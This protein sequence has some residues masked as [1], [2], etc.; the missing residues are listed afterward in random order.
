MGLRRLSGDD[1]HLLGSE[2]EEQK[3][4]DSPA[5]STYYEACIAHSTNAASFCRRKISPEPQQ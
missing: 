5:Q 4:C 1:I 2:I 3:K